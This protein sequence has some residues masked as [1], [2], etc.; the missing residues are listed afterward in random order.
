MV[1]ETHL[2]VA[3]GFH[4]FAERRV[5]FD[6]EL[7]HRPILT[8]DLQVYVFVALRLHAFLWEEVRQMTT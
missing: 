4:E 8:C 6:L 2:S 5:P 3:V 7:H 1:C